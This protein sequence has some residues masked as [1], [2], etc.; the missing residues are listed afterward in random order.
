M[1]ASYLDEHINKNIRDGD[2]P[3]KTG[4]TVF[5]NAFYSAA[6]DSRDNEIQKPVI[7]KLN[8]HGDPLFSRLE[9]AFNSLISRFL[10]PNL[11]S[12]QHYVVDKEVDGE[13]LGI[14]SEHLIIE[15][16]KKEQ[17]E[18]LVFYGINED[19]ESLFD[20]QPP[21]NKVI[22]L[23][24]VSTG[25]L[26]RLLQMEK[27][28]LCTIDMASLASILTSSYTLEEDDLHKGNIAFYII[29]KN[30]KPHVVFQKIDHDLLLADSIMSRFGFRLANW[31]YGKKA[32]TITPRDLLSF[33][34]LRDAK[35]HYWPTS[36]RFLISPTDEKTY[37]YSETNVFAS[38]ANRKDFN[39]AKWR[40]FY[41][42][43]LIPAKLIEQDL[44][45]AYKLNGAEE[46]RVHMLTH[47]VVA[48]QAQLRAAL[49]SLPEFRQFASQLFAAN[50]HNEIIAEILAGIPE[51]QQDKF[52][53]EITSQF[54]LHY[55]LIE[56]KQF[57]EKD[58]PLHAAI[59]LG[60]Y[61]FDETW[62][63]FSE[64]AEDK[65]AKK[66][67]PLELAID[68]QLKNP[69]FTPENN[70][71]RTDPFL[72][73]TH[74]LQQGVNSKAFDDLPA[75]K[76][77]R[78]FTRKYFL[79]YNAKDYSQINAQEL[80]QRIQRCSVD[81]RYSLRTK[82]EMAIVEL[83]RFIINNRHD[84]NHLKLTLI[85]FKHHLNGTGQHQYVNPALLFIH[86]LR[87]SLWIVRLIR[88]LWGD[89]TT[90][91]MMN[92]RIDET[93]ANL[94]PSNYCGSCCF[95]APEPVKAIP[96]VSKPQPPT[97]KV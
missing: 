16:N 91:A 64:Y 49:F 86:Q 58:S 19:S 3:N 65:N 34:F 77:N 44:K 52:K 57:A 61:R 80:V 95:F 31:Y 97:I 40:S 32:F 37:G 71:I 92:Q 24:D 87:S 74:L 90:L 73:A 35:N 84:P 94:T 85:D 47:A 17:E 62:D 76:Q 15:I 59:R 22:F 23:E 66:Q 54:D 26:A 41:K 42:H 29:Q 21:S 45:V 8:K 10:S 82:K 20:P 81:Y 4:H 38:L 88:G 70:D 48:R 63:A 30:G 89:T 72:I 53:R 67:T 14:A 51:N 55:N 36:F 79:N 2:D 68:L 11:T 33:P 27:D 39:L 75:A 69:D 78:S 93:I 7:Y 12:V 50:M 46:A 25:F 83:N 13:I 96:A 5:K 56:T 9:M 43:T 6:K 18:N 28:R 60:D 1:S